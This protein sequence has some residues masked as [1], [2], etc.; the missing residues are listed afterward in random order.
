MWSS[1]AL[2][3][4]L[5]SEKKIEP[6]PPT[7][8]PKKVKED[9]KIPGTI[10]TDDLTVDTKDGELQ[11]FTEYRK[12]LIEERDK[13]MALRRECAI[14][15]S[16]AAKEGDT[17]MADFYKEEFDGHNLAIERS[18]TQIDQTLESHQ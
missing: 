10:R 14:E 5:K 17:D 13:A 8:P 2:I 12:E 4:E 6:P 11:V 18:R 15:K 3:V 7:P 9:P 1:K 16:K